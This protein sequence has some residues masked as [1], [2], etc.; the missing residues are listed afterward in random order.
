[1]KNSF[2]RYWYKGHRCY[3]TIR[4]GEAPNLWKKDKLRND[5]S[6]DCKTIREEDNSEPKQLVGNDLADN[7]KKT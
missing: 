1:M 5:L 7:L 2:K 3:Y 4:K 6:E